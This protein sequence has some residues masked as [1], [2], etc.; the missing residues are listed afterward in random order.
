[1]LQ[2][3]LPILQTRILRLREAKLWL[4]A[5]LPGKG[6]SQDFTVPPPPLTPETHSLR[7]HG[8][9]GVSPQDWGLGLAKVL[10]PL[11]MIPASW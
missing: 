5:Y 6:Q 2:I 1:M 3:D 8:D 9:L 10:E 11:A 4:Q 7:A